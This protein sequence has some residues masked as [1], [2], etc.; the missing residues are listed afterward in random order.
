[1]VLIWGSNYSIVKNAFREIPPLGFNTLRLLLASLI[2]L[3]AIAASGAPRPSRRDW[4][5][6]GGLA[7][8]GHFAYQLCFM[9]GLARTS[10]A[11]SALIIGCSPVT[12]TL[13]TAFVG[14]E[15]ISARQW[16]GIAVSVSGVY[17]VVGFGAATSGAS[18][19][20]DLLTVGAVLCWAVY[21]VGSRPLLERH[22]ALVVTGYSMALGTALYT[23][24]GLTDLAR[25]EWSGVSLAA[26]TAVVFSAVFALFLA[27]WIWYTA[28]QRIGNTR[29]A[30]YSNLVPLVGL[31]VAALWLGEPV[32]A[33][34][35][36]G[37]AAIIGGIVLT[38]MGGAPAPTSPPEA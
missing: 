38:R 15:R 11:N 25:M 6:L 19:V 20:G 30:A 36:A 9:N 7:V 35:L 29:T 14:H 31:G 1:M 28:V 34:K 37:A 33:T 27:Y 18:L 21:T 3:A 16:A 5:R 26:W 12:V 4:W 8:I 22:S 23:P 24:F 32:A 10:V 2:F 17:L 13:L